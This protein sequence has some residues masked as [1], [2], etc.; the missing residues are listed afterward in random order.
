MQREP[1]PA[2]VRQNKPGNKP[3][4]DSMLSRLI[5][6]TTTNIPTWGILPLRFFLGIT[7]V[8]AGLDK[9]TS[10]TFFNPNGGPQF[11]GN[12]LQ[13]AASNSAILGGLLNALVVPNAIFFGWLIALAEIWIG[14]AT[15]VGV[16]TRITAFLGAI[17]TAML[18]L[19][20]SG[21]LTQYYLDSD[22]I[23]FFA[24]VTMILI[25]WG[26]YGL[27][28]LFLREEKKEAA[29]EALE[30]IRQGVRSGDAVAAAA[31]G[32]P[33][34]KTG[35]SLSMI[36]SRRTILRIFGAA[37][38][39]AV[40]EIL[41][42]ALRSATGAANAPSGNPGTTSGGGGGGGTGS[43]GDNVIG[44]TKNIP[45]NSATTFTIAGNNDPGVLVHLPND[46]F[47]AYD[48][49]CTHASCTVAYNG[50]SKHLEC[51]CHGS[52]FDPANAAKV[53]G[54]PARSPL[55]NIKI[56]ID[57]SGNILQG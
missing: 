33:P 3:P 6:P 35:F 49:L 42:L 56:T 11:I 12:Q 19:S 31:S 28:A 15:I 54:G 8:Y 48:A 9:V 29:R 1:L 26:S 7:F 5:G 10:S 22:P 30:K 45:L 57:N 34:L 36:T 20:L 38:V 53:L 14:L 21:G 47:V 44:N 52:V 37:G 4:T 18:W 16:F 51:P 24:W 55:G 23:Y 27:D 39:L 50:G 32:G 17:L 41:A 2:T 13:F 25:G 40:G 46:K 43:T